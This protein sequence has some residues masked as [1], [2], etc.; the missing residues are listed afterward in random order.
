MEEDLLFPLSRYSPCV[1]LERIVT[2]SVVLGHTLEAYIRSTYQEIP[3][4]ATRP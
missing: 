2:D 3:Y 4:M 1:Y